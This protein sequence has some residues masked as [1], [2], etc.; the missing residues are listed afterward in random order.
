MTLC[1]CACICFASE[2]QARLGNVQ[3]TC[4]LGKWDQ[5][6]AWI[7]DTLMI[8]EGSMNMSVLVR[9][10]GDSVCDFTDELQS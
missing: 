6:L 5:G 2:H 9:L 7:L 1:V 4:I 10:D 3:E 8:P